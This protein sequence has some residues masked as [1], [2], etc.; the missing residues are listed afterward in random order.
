LT[1]A[2]A[3]FLIGAAAMPAGADS[4]LQPAGWKDPV[5]LPEAIDRNADPHIV[6]IDL[7]ATLAELEFAPGE[8]VTAW[9]YNG[10]VPG[11]LIRIS[12]GDRL[13]VHFTNKLPA[14]TT[15]H[16][17]GLRVPI[18]MDGVPEHSQPE[19][20]PGG[21]FTYDFIVP[22]AGLF[23]YHPHVMSAAQVGYGLYGP[24]LVQDPGDGLSGMDELVL[25]LS[26]LGTVDGG[27]MEPA[28]SGGNTGMVFGREGQHILVNGRR[29]VRLPVRSGVPQRWRILNAAK[30]RFFFLYLGD[31][32]TFTTIGV[33]GGLLESPVTS[34]RLLITTGER[35]D[36]IVTPKGK[37]GTDLI[38]QNLPHNRG[39][40]ST[41][42]RG[43][44]EVMA[45]TIADMP[46]E[47]RAV[48]PLPKR[49]IE[50]LATDGATPVNIDLTI[51]KLRDGNSFYG[52]N[53]VEFAKDKPLHANVGE[54]QVWTIKNTTPWSHPF[55]LH[56]FF[57]QVLDEQGA[58][59]KPLAWKD[60]VNVPLNETVRIAVRFDDR[61]GRW[62]Y[63]CHILDHAD[64][65]LMGIVNV[66]VTGAAPDHSGHGVSMSGSR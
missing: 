38:L 50:P 45:V 20:P 60:T 23:W 61:P 53:G 5:R 64:G 34:D 41:E 13:I 2:F 51:T 65:G 66:G 8:R 7:E 1:A 25:V 15:V 48:P 29:D 11:P 18:Q 39:Y 40:G 52:I 46:E 55:H 26:D 56:G 36:V 17:H 6:E 47:Q 37:P 21:T 12:V 10:G 59:V 42:F 14:P 49:V 30:S 3:V 27:K 19:V 63:H 16:W 22:D 44:P 4:G 9:T 28:D 33:D 35:F 31:G 57:F 54:T 58:P 32:E 43:N 24:L 62:M